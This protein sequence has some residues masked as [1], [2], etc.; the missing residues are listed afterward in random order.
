MN[1]NSYGAI[2][3]G[4]DHNY[5]G[6]YNCVSNMG[7]NL[8][9]FN[10]YNNSGFDN[11]NCN[12]SGFNNYN[13]SGFNNDNCN[14]R[15]FNNYN[16]NNNGFNNDNYNNTCNNVGN[17]DNVYNTYNNIGNNVY[18]NDRNENSNNTILNDVTNTNYNNNLFPPIP[19]IYEPSIIDE[20]V[21]SNF[22]APN[23]N[24]N[25]TITGSINEL[26]EGMK[27]VPDFLGYPL[28]TDE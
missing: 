15:Y 17:G 28:D 24:D 19:T 27:N 6:D 10:N 13:N 2:D 23:I 20:N 5:V 18:N 16:C 25:M 14:N 9:G 7:G 21:A 11:D 22:S 3:G 4:I 26:L 8:Y 1:N 12:N